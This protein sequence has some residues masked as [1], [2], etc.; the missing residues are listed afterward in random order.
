MSKSVSSDEVV[1][2]GIGQSFDEFLE[3]EGILEDVNELAAKKQLEFE[4][5]NGRRV[6]GSGE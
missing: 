5:K 1:Q 4:K 2:D 6:Y 3:E